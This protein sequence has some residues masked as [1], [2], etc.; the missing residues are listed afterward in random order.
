MKKD[1]TQ[2]KIH[3]EAEKIKVKI[4]N[5]IYEYKAP[6]TLII[7]DGNDNK[8]GVTCG[9]LNLDNNVW[10]VKCSNW[11]YQVIIEILKSFYRI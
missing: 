6:N 9:I 5:K 11:E 1:K 3:L 2:K 7:T 8:I 10:G 4:I